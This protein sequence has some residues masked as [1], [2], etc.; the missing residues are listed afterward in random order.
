[1][2]KEVRTVYYDEELQIEAYRRYCIIAFRRKSFLCT[3]W[4]K[5]IGL[6]K[7]WNFS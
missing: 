6:S 3:T 1:M 5:P 7:S 4:R 2:K